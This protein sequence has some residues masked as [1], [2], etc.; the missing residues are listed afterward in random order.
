MESYKTK[1]FIEAA[2]LLD[3]SDKETR[4]CVSCVNESEQQEILLGVTNKLYEKIEAKVTDIDFGTIPQSKGDFVKIDNIDMVTEA[5][6]DM[7]KIYIEY[8][9]PLT[10]INIIT[11]AI[12][13]LVE[14]KNEFQ[15]CFLTNTDLGILIY[16]T[17]AVSVISAVSLLIS[18]TIDFIVDPKTK[19]IEVSV[20]KVGVSKGKE[21]LQLK[22][23][24]EF[25]NLCKGNK[26]KKVLND[27][28]KVSSKNLLGT[29]ALAVIGASISLIFLIVPI[30]R[31][32]IYYFYYCRATVAEYFKIQ[33]EMIMLNAARLEMA[34]D[35]KIASK[36]RKLVD[37]FRTIADF[38]EVDAKTASNK[39]DNE[40]KQDKKEKYKIDDVTESLPDSAASSLF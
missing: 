39:S 14:L 29:S 17:T 38:L 26:L 3:I 8:K 2:K 28:I 40:L 31:E 4:I 27:L 18:S 6:T 32:L 10:Y 35:Q 19:S 21:L 33:N 7:K 5:I 23:L 15:R 37:G 24:V 22:T 25:N 9:Q 16:N 30:L 13:N 34:G 36:Q 1:E 11:D 12:E 20:D